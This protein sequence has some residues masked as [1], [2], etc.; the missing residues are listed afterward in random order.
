MRTPRSVERLAN[1]I[2]AAARQADVM[3]KILGARD[4]ARLVVGRQPH[5]LRF[6]ELGILK[7]R[8][9]KQAVSKSRRQA[10]LGDVD[11][12]AEDEF[13]RRRQITDD[14]RFLRST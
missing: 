12:I 10:F 5:R 7:R 1:I 11:L 8:Q 9:P 3:R 14:R 13:Q 4:D 2:K 6:V